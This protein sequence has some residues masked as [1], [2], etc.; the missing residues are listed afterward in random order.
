[1][2]AGFYDA[3]RFFRQQVGSREVMLSPPDIHLNPEPNTL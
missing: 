3:R 1:M 2:R